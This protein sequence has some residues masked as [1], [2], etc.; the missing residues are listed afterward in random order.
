MRH[1]P[2]MAGSTKRLAIYVALTA[3][4]LACD[5]GT[6]P[7]VIPTPVLTAVSPDSLP[8]GWPTTTITVTGTGFTSASQ[9][10][11][12]GVR[13]STGFV[14]LTMLT[15]T[16]RDTE[17]AV[18]G[19]RY[20][21]VA[22]PGAGSSA[23]LPLRIVAS[24]PFIQQ[25]VPAG[26]SVGQPSVILSVVGLGF[27]PGAAVSWDGVDRPTAVL[28]VG[29]LAIV[30]DQED[31]AV[32]GQH[33]VRVR[34]QSA[35]F[36][37]SPPRQFTVQN[38][39]PTIVAT[40][41]HFSSAG[42]A[43][44]TLTVDGTAFVP[45]AVVRW[46]DQPRPTT[47]VSPTRVTAAIPSTDVAAA[48]SV[49]VLV[50]NPDPAEAVSPPQG[51]SIHPAGR[52]VLPF[53][54]GDFLWDP[55]HQQLY[56]S[57]LATDSIYPNRLIALDPMTGEVVRSVFVGSNPTQLAISD[58]ASVLYVALDGAAA[59]RRVDLATFTAGLQFPVG[60]YRGTNSIVYANDIEVRPG[61]PGTVAITFQMHGFNGW[62]PG[63]EVMMY[64]DGVPRKLSTW[65][66]ATIEF[67]GPDTLYGGGTGGSEARIGVMRMVVTDS[68]AVD[69]SS[70]SDLPGVWGGDFAY[71]DG[72]MFTT[73]GGVI[74]LPR[75]QA[76]GPLAVYGFIGVDEA[77]HRVFFMADTTLTA[78]DASTLQV[79]GTQRISGV[80]P[81]SQPYYYWLP[82]PLA[83]WG[84]DGFAYRGVGGLVIFRTGL[85]LP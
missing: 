1:N 60:L 53:D 47:F 75:L 13:R 50:R 51:F 21:S 74:D 48:G 44:F 56:V 55:V 69:D 70:A 58:D 28:D 59:I 8:F 67:T 17:L 68:G 52:H 20:V 49:T 72:S 11:L 84:N 31:L 19:V 76:R 66:G 57:I 36:D 18:P 24:T 63:A 32:A 46:N 45:G 26:V 62:G 30:L 9:V 77:T 15:S 80:P 6:G 73:G 71:L 33:V 42:H 65:S 29:R 41:P 7:P 81:V 64:D 82:R 85:A 22:T 34:Q 27:R 14:S 54:V 78:V 12:D 79:L 23:Q 35:P 38:P 10:E 3:A 39:R 5:A 43:N 4:A 83:R 16:V 40:T 61:H 37:S 2:G 25:L